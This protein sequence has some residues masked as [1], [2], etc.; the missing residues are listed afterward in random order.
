MDAVTLSELRKPRP[1][2]AVSVLL[3]VHRGGSDGR[4]DPDR[5]RDLLAQARR[6]L[7]E[8]P[9]VP[10]A[11]AEEVMGGLR[12]A[13]DRVDLERA[14]EGVAL[15][16]APDG[17][18]HAFV[19]DQ[20]PAEE[21]VVVDHTFATRDLIA[22][23]TRTTRYWL[24]TLADRARLWDGR[25]DGL[26]EVLDGPFPM[27][28]PPGEGE[29][30]HRAVAAAL[31]AVTGRDP[32]PVVVAGTTPDQARFE[33]AAHGSI[34]LAG[35]IDGDRSDAG[36]DELAELA[37]PV[38]A[39]YEDLREVAVLTE[40]EAARSLRR[41][42]CGLTDVARL[43][44][45]GRGAHLVVERGY[46]APAVRSPRG[47]LIPVDGRRPPGDVVDDAVDRVIE[48]VLEY[49]G[50]VTLVSDGFLV[51]HDRIALVV[52]Y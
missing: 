45:E 52:R 41:Y 7:E 47:D 17:E 2:P 30:F 38:L 44:E 6:R 46:C 51:D 34:I 42:A 28:R 23:H 24:L 32:R 18:R 16:A 3:S 50:E 11:L 33:A 43:A 9:R 26:T 35:R 27:T 15:Y 37:R 19:L 39:A 49:G 25:A 36:A 14:R 29:G 12:Q 1:Y 4:P 8:D 31:G 5:L 10:P 20:P 40:L 22:A 21:R 48:T 13:A